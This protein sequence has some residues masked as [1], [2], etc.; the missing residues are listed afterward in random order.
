MVFLIG[1][2]IGIAILKYTEPLVRTFGHSSMADKYLG[3]PAG[4]YTMWKLIA[5]AVMIIVFLYLI[6]SVEFGGWDKLDLNQGNEVQIEP[7]D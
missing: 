6:G 7:Y 5:I 2:G 1:M 4:S 3:G